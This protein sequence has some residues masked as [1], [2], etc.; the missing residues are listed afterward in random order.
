MSQRTLTL[1]GLAGYICASA[2]VAHIHAECPSVPRLC[3]RR[4]CIHQPVY[5]PHQP[6]Y[7][8]SC[9]E[10]WP[11]LFCVS[12]FSFRC[13][14]GYWRTSRQGIGRTWRRPESGPPTSSA[15]S[16]HTR[17]TW[18]STST[19]VLL[20]IVYAERLYAV[21]DNF[22]FQRVLLLNIPPL[23]LHLSTVYIEAPIGPWAAVSVSIDS[24][25]HDHSSGSV[26]AAIMLARCWRSQDL[27]VYL[28]C[29]KV[30]MRHS[31]L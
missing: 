15:R 26:N 22:W 29:A 3:C 25:F 10:V 17:S 1:Q 9:E 19:Y 21:C 14:Q 20:V 8:C 16:V 4:Q 12:R 23:Y 13:W 28:V 31:T 11:A 24:N 2:W 5:S 18:N 7:V 30:T 6:T 27:A